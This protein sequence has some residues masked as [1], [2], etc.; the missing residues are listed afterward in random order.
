MKL[1]ELVPAN[2]Q[3]KYGKIFMGGK[4]KKVHSRAGFNNNLS[5]WQG[6]KAESNTPAEE[7]L[8]YRLSLYIN[9]VVDD[10]E[11]MQ[12]LPDLQIL[13][14]E[15]P[16]LQP[17]PSQMVYRGTEIRDKKC[18][19]EII[20]K[21]QESGIENSQSK[22][23]LTIPVNYVA[24]DQ[25]H[26]WSVDEMSAET[27]VRD[28]INDEYTGIS[29]LLEVKADK[30]LNFFFPNEVLYSAAANYMLSHEKEV[31]RFG[32]ESLRCNAIIY[33]GTIQK[34]LDYQKEH[35]DNSQYKEILSTID[36]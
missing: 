9:G 24:R 17:D 27:F 3:D 29:V 11:L 7:N 13:A 2:L 6:N 33:A 20:K 21:Y 14:K 18:L 10:D 36:S 1:Q 12:Y 35:A 32:N 8:A 30:Q 5:K 19:A 34:W 16:W 23:L 4:T 31:L 15:M 26:S 25:I 22:K 28:D